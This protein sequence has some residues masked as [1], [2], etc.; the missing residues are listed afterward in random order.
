MPAAT[1]RELL[2]ELIDYAGL[3]PPAALPLPDVLSNFASYRTS[4]DSWAL[5]RLI[6]PASRLE[7]LARVLPA[8]A[9]ADSRPW[10]VSALIG[11]DTVAD[12]SIIDAFEAQKNRGVLVDAVEVRASTPAEIDAVVQALGTS[13]TVYVEIPVR[14]DPLMLI[15]RIARGG[16]RA[17]IR[18]GGVT[19]DAFPTAAQIARFLVACSNHGV[20]FKATAGLHH[21]MRGEYRL[22]YAADAPRDT[23]FG[24]LNVFVAAAFAQGGMPEATLAEF[25]DERDPRS[26]EFGEHGVAWREHGFTLDVARNARRTF[27]IA[28]GSCSFREPIDDLQQLGLL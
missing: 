27:A 18:T 19:P 2:A 24:F 21:P 26:I 8:D 11:G 4:A 22:T 9:A 15:E 6:V 10:R 5:G 16:V 28:F 20:P 1:L 13:R 3:F 25:L 12:R 7:E 17:K 14:D 23:M